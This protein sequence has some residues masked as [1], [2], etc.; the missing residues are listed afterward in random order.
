[1]KCKIQ[2]CD[3]P[4]RAKGMC[5]KHYRRFLRHGTLS[6]PSRNYRTMSQG[7]WDRILL[8]EPISDMALDYLIGVSG[9]WREHCDQFKRNRLKRIALVRHLTLT[10]QCMYYRRGAFIQMGQS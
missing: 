3:L 5:N 6:V 1:M 9:P 7:E 4:T 2:D 8:M 10:Q